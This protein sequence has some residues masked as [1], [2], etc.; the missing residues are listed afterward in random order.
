MS[1]IKKIMF[2]FLFLILG[3]LTIG[4]CET[5]SGTVYY[6]GMTSTG[7]FWVWASTMPMGQ[8]GSEPVAL[9]SYTVDGNNVNFNYTLVIPTNILPR[10]LFIY[11]ARDW[12]PPFVEDY[13]QGQLQG[14]PIY[15]D[16]L[17]D[18]PGGVYLN[19]TQTLT[20]INIVVKDPPQGRIT[21]TI[22]YE[23]NISSNLVLKVAVGHGEGEWIGGPIDYREIPYPYFPTTYELN[24]LPDATDYYV[25]AILDDNN[26]NTPDPFTKYGPVTISSGNT[27]NVDLTLPILS[28]GKI[29]GTLYYTG[30]VPQ[31]AILR[32]AVGYGQPQDNWDVVSG[33]EIS[34]PSFPFEYTLYNVP[35]GDN[36]FVFAGLVEKMGTTEELRAS[37]LV[38]P[39]LVSSINNHWAINVD[40]TLQP[41]SGGGGGS[42][43]I[44]GIVNY[45]ETNKYP[46]P[47]VLLLFHG[48]I[49]QGNNP[50]AGKTISSPYYPQSFR[51][52]N[53]QDANDY[54]ILAFIDTN[55]DQK[56]QSSQEPY[57]V[58]E[59]ISLQGFK[60]G[61]M[62]TILNP[63]GGGDVGQN[64]LTGNVSYSGATISY[65][66]IKI[67]LGTSSGIYDVKN[68][69]LI[70]GSGPYKFENLP[71]AENYYLE[72]FVDI[73]NNGIWDPSI[74]EPYTLIGPIS[75][76]GGT[77]GWQDINLADSVVEFSTIT[78]TIR[79]RIFLDNQAMGGVIVNLLDTKNDWEPS[80]DE[81]IA[82]T[83]SSSVFSVSNYGV[84]YYNYEFT[85]VQ[86]KSSLQNYNYRYKIKAYKE[87]YKKKEIELYFFAYQD[88]SV[89]YA[90]DIF[91]ELKPQIKV[92]NISITPATITPDNDGVNDYADISF[93][94]IVETL[95]TGYEND[96]RIK[97]IVDTNNNNEFDPI[98][99]SIFV[100]DNQNRIF[101]KKDPNY[102]VDF[103]KP[104]DY[105]K[106]E[107]PI[108]QDEYNRIVASYDS[109]IDYWLNGYN[110]TI[111]ETNNQS[112]A[113]ILLRWDGRNNGQVVKN[114]SYKTL[115]VIEDNYK[116]VVFETP[117]STVTVITAVISGYVK[118]QQGNPIVKA[119]V[120]C[121]NP[122][123]WGET[124]TSEDGS[125]EV[126]GLKDGDSY[127][128]EVQ[129]EGY[130]LSTRDEI[131]AKFNPTEN[132]KLQIVLN[133]GV[134]LSGYIILPRPPKAGEIRD[135]NGYLLY[136][137]W[138][139]LE[140]QDLTGGQWLWKDIMLP[141]S[142]DQV[143]ISSV[144]FT[145]YVKPNSEYRLVAKAPGYI[146]KDV[147]IKVLEDKIT[148]NL[149]LEKA[150]K[151]VGYIKLPDDEIAI[152]EILQASPN[153]LGINIWASSKDRKYNSSSY[154]WINNMDLLPSASKEFII[155]SL[156]P[157]T[158]YTIVIES[159]YFARL[160]KDN[161]YVSGM[162]IILSEPLVLS[163]GVKIT[164]NIKFG[165]G[166]YDKIKDKFKN[167]NTPQGE[168]L[169]MWV[170]IGLQSQRDFSW[171]WHGIPVSTS[172]VANSEEIPFSILGLRAKESYK[173]FVEGDFR[174]LEIEDKFIINIPTTTNIVE[175]S[176][177]I[178]ILIPT[179]VVKGKLVNNTG[180]PIDMSKV[181]VLLVIFNGGGGS[182]TTPNSNGEFVFSNIPTGEGLIWGSEYA[183]KPFE[184]AGDF[185]GIPTGN[186]GMF[187]LPIYAVHGST[188]NLGDI[189][190]EP[191]SKIEVL[192][193]GPQ[194]LI[195]EIYMQTTSYLN[196]I[197]TGQLHTEGPYGLI[198]V[199]P[200][201]L[202][203]IA[204]QMRQQRLQRGE[205][206]NNIE[207][208]EE[209][210]I[211][212]D[213]TIEK[214]N[215]TTLK[216][217]FYGAQE[218]VYS[219]Y[220]MVG[221]LPVFRYRLENEQNKQKAIVDNFTIYPNRQMF[222]LKSGE[223][224]T[225]E[226]T[227]SAGVDITGSIVRP[228]SALGTEEKITIT[229][230]DKFSGKV[231]QETFVNFDEVTKMLTSGSFKFS[232]V[233]PGEYVLVILSP[234]Y[235]AY[236]KS[237]SISADIAS[238]TLTSIYLSKGANIVGRLVDINGN[239]ITTG[240]MVECMA[241]PFVEGSYKNTDMP[242]LEISQET[243]TAGKFS[244]SNL[245][246]GTYIIRVV[247]KQDAQTNYVNTSKIGIVV[248]NSPVDIDIGDI[249]LKP[250]VEITG[251]VYDV[252][253][254][255]PLAGVVVL[256]YPQDVQLRKGVECRAVSG[257]DG[258]F[259]IKGINPSIKLWELKVN[260]REQDIMQIKPELRKYTE[261]VKSYINVTKEEYR[262]NLKVV[263][264]IA[265]AEI[266]GVVKTKD[267]GG[268]LL[269][270]EISGVDIKDYPAAV[271]L[272]QTDRDIASGD[273][274]SG[275]KV[276]T[277][278]DGNFEIKGIS[279]GK[280][281]LKVFAR[282]YATKVVSLDVKEGINNI[283][284]LEIVKGAKVSGTITTE[285][286]QKISKE[287]AKSVV[288]SNK[289][290][291]KMVI[292]FVNYNPVTLEVE[293]YEV[294]GLEIGVTYY[295]AIIP[296]NGDNVVIDPNPLFVSEN[297][298]ERNLVYKKP[299]PHFEVKSYKFK[300]INKTYINNWLQ[301]FEINDLSILLNMPQDTWATHLFIAQLL[302]EQNID[303]NTLSTQDIFDL[304]FIF[305]FINEP[306][307]QEKADDIVS[308]VSAS[309]V[310]AP[311]YLSD[312][313]KQFVLSY[314]PAAEDFNRGYFEFK[315]SAVN[316]YGESGEEIYRFYLGEDAKVEK[317]FTPL[318]GGYAYVG[319]KDDSGLE[320]PA[321]TNFEDVDV[322]SDAKI[323]ITRLEKETVSSAVLGKFAP[324]LFSSKIQSGI[325]SYPG[326]LVSSIYDM[327]VQLISGPLAV[328]SN[329]NKVKV[330]I[331]IDNAISS[332]DK[333]LLKLGY[334]NES[335]NKWEIENVPLDIDWDNMIISADVS[336]L[337]KFA[338]FKVTVSS[339]QPY[340]G[341]FKTYSYPNPV[342][343]VDK[344]NIRYC[345]PGSGKV[346]VSIK[347][348][349]IAGELVRTLDEQEV[350]A[351]YV[352]NVEDIEL[353][354]DKGEKLASGIYFY[355]IKAGDYKKTY[356]FAVIR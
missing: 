83:I 334:F 9:S 349:N 263:L 299:K 91:M 172:A 78:V 255:T 103:S 153:G 151:L 346:K 76:V 24:F 292:G 319:E 271:I 352:Y 92:E 179:G 280:Y 80:N 206:E 37:G 61:V 261:F 200:A 219:V 123:S 194:D 302:R 19:P 297:V 95:Q 51:L 102:Y 241:V 270:F 43:V 130:V 316:L 93:R 97:F 104:L 246:E 144:P 158:T 128:L 132:D 266:K 47:L 242:G 50:V 355:Y 86:V 215:E 174:E 347:I 140:A 183:V 105:S 121:G 290:F 214:V 291:S 228:S 112:Y 254:K 288:A 169:G 337:S 125:F 137:L 156:A 256:A 161:I 120:N 177:P 199:Q 75:L 22:Y 314:V 277:Y 114:G 171:R 210:S 220:A 235:K 294:S 225:I 237:L 216:Y 87:G 217:T 240:V 296:E 312:T 34:N 82:T 149:Q 282:G 115:L 4:F 218:G 12:H 106:L 333:D 8:E 127:H 66:R 27:V 250:A 257:V 308:I 117:L 203:K 224:K 323:I 81:I 223:I 131:K 193:K 244:L 192:L 247:N 304:Y 298:M 170:S 285:T 21:G 41:V 52:D 173:I 70:Y 208:I 31:N 213:D 58:S 258:S 353:T 116:D 147:V 160:Q 279:A 227:V 249:V 33:Q 278:P 207:E 324:K 49:V 204:E 272:L 167:I 65:I 119:K 139:H 295:L 245:P 60:S 344:F 96:A 300:N 269:P 126:S 322:Y 283:G 113:D 32:I 239:P 15:G 318:T 138:I 335:K 11:A 25:I 265:N 325:L 201:W 14:N 142:Y 309:G 124:F 152:S 39:I 275:L 136:N 62:I 122:S 321:G 17:G 351:G 191:A 30:S 251:K 154:I 327:K 29:S 356:K 354:N 281:V 231:V 301:F 5:I 133:K 267:G 341:E 109:M 234:N 303:V 40:I 101:I 110:L 46:G 284:E 340:S 146:S 286:G 343:G 273:P 317:V 28:S 163:L 159:P 252:D 2:V 342:K 107:G 162:Q 226:L 166:C 145:I 13:L 88:G 129:A 178:N 205:D 16:P 307:I 94:Y 184:K 332:D 54:K 315:F 100:M 3:V 71:D 48:D 232:K 165:P 221:N 175:L 185:F 53:L 89:V 176:K 310:M 85:N 90:S 293:S 222:Q 64:S 331:K 233:S 182:I 196:M 287:N 345:L 134:E 20:D 289:D 18:Y 338:I 7:K 336:H 72:A 23:G 306:I 236:S 211:G 168:I 253:G 180:K 69:I 311:M 26:S 329:N 59:I 262:T 248:P 198:R 330:K 42:G 243:L 35:D 348:Y 276:L 229:L 274:M 63:Q 6:S 148:T 84:D 68:S 10:Q 313:R 57:G 135:N 118:D 45:P 155:D 44:E 38:G 197:A 260:P 189:S 141:L 326:E 268:L 195:G 74:M 108:T 73:N 164:G 238:L 1:K 350:D 150:A 190:L 188:V 209:I 55:G 212:L 79:G 56:W 181:A 320:V 305:G 328:L 111:D 36:F 67:G 186:A 339:N 187:G 230:R 259:R 157:N 143:S 202:R 264:N 98:D 77:Y 99:P